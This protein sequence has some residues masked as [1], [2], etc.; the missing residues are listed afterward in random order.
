MGT[1]VAYQRPAQMSYD[2]F[3]QVIDQARER[4]ADP[5]TIE[6][7]ERKLFPLTQPRPRNRSR[8]AKMDVDQFALAKQV[9]RK[10]SDR[11]HLLLDVFTEMFTGLDWNTGAVMLSR[12]DIAERIDARPEH[13]SRAIS[14]LRRLGICR[15]EG[16]GRRVRYYVN[17]RVAFRGDRQAHE[18]ATAAAPQLELI[19]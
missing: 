2:L 5:E 17:E 14:E 11:P 16:R 15:A 3:R 12:Q 19:K 9:I 7:L 1:V 13:V 18:A 4:G 6:E 8:W 10:H